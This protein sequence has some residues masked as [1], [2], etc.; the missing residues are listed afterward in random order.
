MEV[1][2]AKDDEL[3]HAVIE[4]EIQ[5][6]LAFEHRKEILL[7]GFAAFIGLIGLRLLSLGLSSVDV[8]LLLDLVGLLFGLFLG[9]GNTP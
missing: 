3:V 5:D 9:H 8:N 6:G 1:A 7:E 4:L 2:V